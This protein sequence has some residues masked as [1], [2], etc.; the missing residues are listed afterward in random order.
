[1]ATKL[2]VALNLTGERS[3]SYS[4]SDGVLNGELVLKRM[5][6]HNKLL[7]VAYLALIQQLANIDRSCFWSRVVGIAVLKSIAKVVFGRRF[8]IPRP[9]PVGF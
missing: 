5:G 1:M 4:V 8:S 3:S 2:I 7:L 6:N 9:F